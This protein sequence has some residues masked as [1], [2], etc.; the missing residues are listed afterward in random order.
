LG[1]QY[2]PAY[3]ALTGEDIGN[4]AKQYSCDNPHYQQ[5]F[6]SSTENLHRHPESLVCACTSVIPKPMSIIHIIIALKAS[7][8]G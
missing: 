4:R 3:G 5:S 1:P 8:V 2:Y 7:L 6:G